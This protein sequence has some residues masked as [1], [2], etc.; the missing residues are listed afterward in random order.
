[1]Y[2]LS[3]SGEKNENEWSS[4]VLIETRVLIDAQIHTGIGIQQI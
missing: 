4:L 2:V 1:M 3:I